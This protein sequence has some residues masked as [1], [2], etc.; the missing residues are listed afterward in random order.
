MSLRMRRG[1]RVEGISTAEYGPLPNEQTIRDGAK[2]NIVLDPG[3]GI[4]FTG[5]ADLQT[6]INANPVN[7][8]FV[9]AGNT[10]YNW[11]AVVSTGAKHP[12]IYFL[13]DPE[14][15]IING[16]GLNISGGAITGNDNGGEIH[17]GKFRNFGTSSESSH[18]LSIGGN[19]LAED[20]ISENNFG[21][22]IGAGSSSLPITMRRVITRNNGRYGFNLGQTQLGVW[23]A[24][25]CLIEDVQ[26]SGNN[27]R[28][29][30][31]D[32]DAGGTKFPAGGGRNSTFRRCWVHDNYGAGLWWDGWHSGI[33]VE[34]CVIEN[35]R[36]WGLFLELGWGSTMC[37]RLYLKGNGHVTPF[38]SVTP[39]NNYKSWYGTVQF[40]VSCCD[41]TLVA[42]DTGTYA[43][44]I[45]GGTGITL[46]DS[47]IDT[48]TYAFGAITHDGHPI[49]T[50]DCHF[51]HNQVWLR[52]AVGIPGSTEQGG[53]IGGMDAD[54]VQI[55]WNE[56]MEFSDNEY[57][58]ANVATD[59]FKWAGSQNG[60]VRDFTEW[61]AFGK[62][63]DSSMVVIP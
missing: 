8:I 37:R 55:L 35:N 31:V 60:D 27:T 20:L 54:S 61:K 22:G 2:P 57:H 15:C 40:L 7:S 17:G 32:A 18:G 1:G 11:D 52:N 25:G 53:Q 4:T 56:V 45:A 58:V 36:N 38:D 41:G 51:I 19:W 28:H 39:N 10:T 49:P 44:G 30:A 12:R 26:I 21:L 43:T 42:N 48:D 23:G 50:K 29:L 59:Y 6:K 13:G 14:L 63:V 62:D 34:D 47:Y 46:R 24:K 33:L 9:A 3:G 16:Q 5:R